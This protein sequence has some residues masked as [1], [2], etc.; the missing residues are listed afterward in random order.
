MSN[1]RRVT[2]DR[3]AA[4]A[5]S[6]IIRAVCVISE[7]GMWSRHSLSR[8]LPTGEYENTFRSRHCFECSTTGVSLKLHF[9]GASSGR[10]SFAPLDFHL[11]SRYLLGRAFSRS[12]AHI[13]RSPAE[14]SHCRRRVLSF[15]Y[16][17]N[18]VP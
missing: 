18:C 15:D 9:S 11:I 12:V 1:G 16:Y 10:D 2:A 8:F 13:R 4:N 7:A 5:R 14:S 6:E 17:F 3:Q